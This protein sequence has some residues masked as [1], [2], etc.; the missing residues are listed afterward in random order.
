[1]QYDG[2][3]CLLNL[4]LKHIAIFLKLVRENGGSGSLSDN[5]NYYFMNIN[6]S[7]KFH[8]KILIFNFENFKYSELKHIKIYMHISN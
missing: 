8:T 6:I 5:C 7:D 4:L 2:H 3:E 1:M